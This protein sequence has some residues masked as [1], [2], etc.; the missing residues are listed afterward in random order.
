MNF[1]FFSTNSK[2]KP[3]TE[4]EIKDMR[5]QL[6]RVQLKYLSEAEV[7]DRRNYIFNSKY[8][9]MNKINN[10]KNKGQSLER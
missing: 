9:F 7:F 8:Q 5:D 3:L 10:L 1:N 2:H 6:N 4:D